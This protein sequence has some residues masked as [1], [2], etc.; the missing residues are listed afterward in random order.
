MTFTINATV[1]VSLGKVAGVL[2]CAF[3]GGSNY[4]YVINEFIEP[5]EIS[6]D[7]AKDWGK[8]RYISYPLSEGGALLIGDREDE[9]E[10]PKRLDLAAVAKGVQVMATKYPSHFADMMEENDDADTGD[11][12][13]QCCLFGE[14]VYA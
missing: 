10:E 8:Y 11:V 13:L 6:E 3:E 12:L 7:I 5:K 1:E 2:N 4:W 9:D 14:L